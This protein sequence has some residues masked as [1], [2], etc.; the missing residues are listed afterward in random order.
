MPWWS[1]VRRW[2]MSLQTSLSSSVFYLWHSC[3]CEQSA[4]LCFLPGETAWKCVPLMI[5]FKIKD[6]IS[7]CLWWQTTHSIPINIITWKLW[8]AI[9][10]SAW[11]VIWPNHQSITVCHRITSTYQ[12]KGDRT[13]PAELVGQSKSCQSQSWAKRS[14]LSRKAFSAVVFLLV[15]QWRNALLIQQML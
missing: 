13:L 3:S 12:I 2:E 10:K 11:Q 6:E 8:Q 14:F 5:L 15:F 4:T 7:P 1:A 9:S